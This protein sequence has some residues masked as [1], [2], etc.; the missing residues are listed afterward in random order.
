MYYHESEIILE[1][2]GR[3]VKEIEILDDFFAHLDYS[4]AC[5][6]I[7]DDIINNKKYNLNHKIVM[8]LFS[9]YVELGFLSSKIML[10]C[11][12]DN[13]PEYIDELQDDT[14]LPSLLYCDICERE[15]MFT[16]KDTKIV[17]EGNFEIINDDQ[18]EIYSD[19]IEI[20]HNTG[21]QMQKTPHIY[22]GHDEESLRFFFLHTLSSHYSSVTGESYNHNGKTDILVKVDDYQQIIIEFKF[23]SGERAFLEA[24]DQLI[25]YI[26]IDDKYSSLVMMNKIN[27]NFSR[28]ISAAK[29]SISEHS[30]FIKLNQEIYSNYSLYEFKH[31]KDDEKKLYISIIFFDITM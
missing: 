21:L 1:Q 2:N 30:S 13:T 26:S 20:I 18:F 6:I 17:Y 19:C 9:E 4:Q 23:W 8:Y 14:V 31:P 22:A 15:H 3:Y 29:E 16:E 24:I 25:G 28:I 27:K 5:Q 11:N 10:V 7:P 12:C